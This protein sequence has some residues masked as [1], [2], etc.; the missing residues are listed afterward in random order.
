[1]SVANDVFGWAATAAADSVESIGRS[2]ESAQVDSYRCRLNIVDAL[3][4]A[5]AP[6]D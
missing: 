2:P 1:V 6:T 4:R 5:V 3:L